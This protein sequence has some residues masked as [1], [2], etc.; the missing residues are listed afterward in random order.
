MNRLLLLFATV[1]TA[2]T[3]LVVSSASAAVNATVKYHLDSQWATG[4]QAGIK[5][6]NNAA[7]T[8]PA[9]KLEFDFPHDISSVWDATIT[10][11]N[12]SHYVIRGAA[13]DKDLAGNGE[14]HFGFVAQLAGAVS[15]PQ[16]CKLNGV[17]LSC[18]G[19]AVAATAT[20][21]KKPR[22]TKT[23]TLT[24]TP[25]RN[26]SR[27]PTRTATLTRTFTPTATSTAGPS[28]TPIPSHFP[29]RVFAPYVDVLL[30]PTPNI[31]TFAQQ[32]GVKYYTLAFIVSGNGCSASWGGVVPLSDNFYADEIAALRQQ[33]GDVI[34]SFG[35]AN[36]SELGETCSTVSSLQSQY[37]AVIDQYQVTHIDFD[38]EGGAQQNTAAI[39]R[40]NQAIAALQANAS[41]HGKTLTVSYTLPVLPTGLT[42]D[43]VKI[44]QNAASRGVNVAVANVMA[45]DYGDASIADPHKMGDNA[46]ASAASL[47]GQL[48]TLYPN[49]TDAQLWHMVGVTPMIGLNDVS[50]EVFTVADAQKLTTFAQQKNIGRLAM[51]SAGR[52]H[53]CPNNG[54]YTAPDCSGI[55]QSP[56]D[57][58]NVFKAITQ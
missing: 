24:A 26:V 2:L 5:I 47:H 39:D 40:R 57:F 27:T 38:I 1:L 41:A 10:A 32:T 30:W 19:K 4:L 37:Q 33:G 15:K 25:T 55:V 54:A 31:A 18:N 35:G 7:T 22:K 3:L 42:N 21:T 28:P 29:A 51:W 56:W 44:L 13:W 45:M 23:A 16:N 12:G 14:I 34:I 53:S 8:L 20:P 46:I 49:K 48:K 17:A 43:G 36:G 58:S 52:D 50:P 9:W 11:H 6:K